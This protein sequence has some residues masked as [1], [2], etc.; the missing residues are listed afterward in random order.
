[1]CAFCLGLEP[2]HGRDLCRFD[3]RPPKKARHVLSKCVPAAVS[4]V[5]VNVDNI[6]NG[7]MWEACG[8]GAFCELVRS[9][10]GGVNTVIHVHCSGGIGVTIPR[11]VSA[12]LEDSTLLASW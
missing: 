4:G 5:H 1:M 3:P 6:K 8:C 2:R 10:G 12:L 7:Y 9:P 11:T